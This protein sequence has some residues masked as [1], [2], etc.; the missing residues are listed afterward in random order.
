MEIK[1][2][3]IFSLVIIVS[4]LAG[5]TSIANARFDPE[6][7]TQVAYVKFGHFAPFASDV[8]A[9]EVELKFGDSIQY[10][11]KYE[12]IKPFHPDDVPPPQSYL[13]IEA[14]TYLLEVTPVGSV[15]PVISENITID[16]LTYNTIAVVGNITQQPVEALHLV[17]QNPGTISPTGALVRVTHAAPFA[18]NAQDLLVDI[19]VDDQ[20]WMGL[21]DVPYKEFTDTYMDVV[22]GEYDIVVTD[23]G[24][25]CQTVFYS[26]P[27]LYFKIGQVAD[28]FVIG[29]IA[30]QELDH[31]T[32]TG[33]L[34]VVPTISGNIRFGHFSQ[35]ADTP[36]ASS[37]TIRIDGVDELTDVVFK[38]TTGYMEI[39]PGPHTVEVIPTGSVT[40][41]ATSNIM[42]AEGMYYTSGVIGDNDDQPIEIYTL[43]DETTP[44]DAG[45]KLRI[46]H[47][48]PVAPAIADT[49]VDICS[50]GSVFN[51]L[52]NVEYKQ[53]TDPYLLVAAGIY[54]LYVAAPDGTCTNMLFPIDPF[55]LG[56]LG[57][58]DLWILDNDSYCWDCE[59]AGEGYLRI[60]HFSQ[61][62]PTQAG[63]SVTVRIDGVDVLTNFLFK[64]TTDYTMYDA[65]SHLIEVLPTGTTTVVAS[66][67]VMIADGEYYTAGVIGDNDD[68]PIEIYTLLDETDEP[69]TGA[70][71]RIVHAAPVAPVLAD[72]KVDICSM[73]VLFEGLTNVQYKQYTDPYLAVDA[74]IFNL[75]VAA[76]DGTCANLLWSIYAFSLAEKGIGDLWILDRDSYCWDCDDVG[77]APE[78]NLAHVAPFEDNSN[79]NAIRIVVDNVPIIEDFFFLK[80]SGYMPMAPGTHYVKMI[81]ETTDTILATGWITL[82]ADKY[83]TLHL[84]GNGDEQP[85]EVWL[86]EDEIDPLLD[87]AKV[88]IVNAA[89]ISNILSE[90]ELDICNAENSLI[91]PGLSNIPYKG[92]DDPY[93]I[94]DPG[95]YRIKGTQSGT[96]CVQTIAGLYPY[97]FEAGDVATIYIFGDFTIPT[98]QVSFPDLSAYMVFD[99][100]VLKQVNIIP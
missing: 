38:Q 73:G 63:S 37:V 31:A 55:G 68:Q 80:F 72:T 26:F 19:C 74:G 30:N 58:G 65:G 98:G 70:K 18:N 86:L 46:V 5:I 1:K 23:A 9:T 4:L 88:R 3:H 92:Y 77:G 28:M 7:A 90:T 16:G 32:T 81:Q 85:T 93:K 48:A 8:D 61:F 43:L 89:P 44:P 10:T 64:D 45:A 22:Q 82:E 20:I 67:T 27:R 59:P 11:F 40:P 24:S 42:I 34:Y 75:Y 49:K 99:N 95:F 14:G 54:N 33:L 79:L 17:D 41:V 35:F 39:D 57:I 66:S 94:Y 62:S 76:P 97:L 21:E 69:A 53:Y 51:G 78:V 13:E 2:L 52:T 84:I 60:G 87:M 25:N 6:Q 12:D 100:I 56:E 36:E 96:N 91:H 71:L 50:E 15:T 83:Y 29:D 47:A